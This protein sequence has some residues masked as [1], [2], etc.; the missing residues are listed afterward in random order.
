MLFILGRQTIGAP[1]VRTGF[2]YLAKGKL[3]GLPPLSTLTSKNVLKMRNQDQIALSD[4][5][6]TEEINALKVER[7]FMNTEEDEIVEMKR[8]NMEKKEEDERV[9]RE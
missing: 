2:S 3:H 1:G 7:G 5:I 6:T 8:R 9:K 4:Y